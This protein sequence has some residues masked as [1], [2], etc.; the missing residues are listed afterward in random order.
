MLGIDL[1][2]LQR[3]DRTIGVL[4]YEHQVEQADGAAADQIGQ[5]G[6]DR[7]VEPVARESQ[8]D[9]VDRTD[10]H[11][12]SHPAGDLRYLPAADRESS[13]RDSVGF[14]RD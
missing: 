3:T 5:C 1:L 4:V 11:G 7:P 2:E 6:Q 12:L 14:I 10:L 9:D 13:T 8:D